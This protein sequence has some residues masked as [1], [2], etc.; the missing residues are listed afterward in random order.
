MC[1]AQQHLFVEL[2]RRLKFFIPA[3]GIAKPAAPYAGAP[4]GLTDGKYEMLKNFRK[5]MGAA[6]SLAGAVVLVS[7]HF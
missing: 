4:S 5:V 3:I 6:I 7:Q 1:A 2:A